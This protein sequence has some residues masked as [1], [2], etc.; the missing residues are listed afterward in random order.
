MFTAISRVL[1]VVLALVAAVFLIVS[2]IALIDPVGTQMADDSDP[3]GPPIPWY[4]AAGMA[5][6]STA[7]GAAGVW[8]AIRRSGPRDRAV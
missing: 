2:L 4:G 8:L 1:G 6:A 7:V 5:I 3:F